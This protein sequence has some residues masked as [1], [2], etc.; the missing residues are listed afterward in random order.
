MKFFILFNLI[1]GAVGTLLRIDDAFGTWKREHG[2]RYKSS[3]EDAYR[4]EV[5][6]NNS[7]YV[8][9]SNGAGRSV[10]L[11]LNKFAGL[12]NDE[13]TKKYLNG[14][15]FQVVRRNREPDWM[16][17]PDTLPGE[18]DWV[19]AGA[20]TPVKNQGDCGSCWSFS[21]TGAM[22]G[23]WFLKT[24]ELVSLSEQQLVDCSSPEGNQGCNGGFMD[25]AFEYVIKNGGIC[26]EGAYSYQGV[27]GTCQKCVP[28]A[29]FTSYMD[30][31]AN[32]SYALQAAVAQQPVSVAVEADGLDWQFYF[33]GVVTDGC[34]LNLDHGVLVVGY[35]TIYNSQ[36]QPYWKVKNSW[37]ADWGMGGYILIGR[38]D[39]YGAAGECGIQMVPSFPVV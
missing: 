4:R 25:N 34:G 29:N 23:A 36:Q 24:G 7:R 18:V 3:E 35:G 5:F 20:V 8:D 28:V 9:W 30:V 32:N 10:V 13:F 39:A 2:I 21:S 14:G 38:G 26:S 27:Q 16:L 31:L 6:Y 19:A 37:G 15:N 22:E 1:A 33:G 17:V 11:K 12:T